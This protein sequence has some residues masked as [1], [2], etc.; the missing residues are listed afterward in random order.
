[1]VISISLVLAILAL[2]VT[3]AHAMGKAPLWIA[4]LL[5]AILALVG[6]LPVR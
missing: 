5:L 1:M 6:L 4:V 3:V 2:A